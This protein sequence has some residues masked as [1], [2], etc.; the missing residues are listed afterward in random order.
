MIYEIA[1]D[2]S[3]SIA[4]FVGM[5]LRTPRQRRTHGPDGIYSQLA[6]NYYRKDKR[7]S[8]TRIIYNF[9]RADQVDAEALRRL[10]QSL[11]RVANDDRIDLP[12]RKFPPDVGIDDIEQVYTYGVLYAARALWEELGIGPLLR[13]KM[14]QDGCAA[15]HD[16]ALLALTANR[17]AR[18]TSKLACY[19]QWLAD[20]VYWPEAK[21][22]ALE[23]LYRAMDFLLRHIASLEQE[24]FYRTADRFN[25]DVDLVFWDTTTL[26]FEID[27]EDETGEYWR[28]QEIPALRKR[29][30][31]KDGRDNNPQVVVGLALTRDGLPVRSWVFPGN[32]ADVTTIEHLKADL[33]GW[34]LNRC[35]FVGDSGMFSEANQQ[36]LSRALGRDILAVPMRKVTEVPLEVLSR[37]GRYREVA[38]NL[39][40]KEV[41][42]GDGERRRRYLVC[43]NSEEAERE[44]AHRDRLLELVRAEIAVLDTRAEDHPKPACELIASRR[45]GRYLTMDARGRLS[46]NATKVA[47]EATYDGKFVLTTN[48]DTLD[49][50]D[51]ALGY[52]SMMLIEG[53]FR[54]MK[55]TGLQTRPVYH[56]KPHRIIAH[57]KLCVLALRLERAAEIRCQNTWRHIRQALDQLQVVRYRMHGKTIG[58]STQVTPTVGKILDRLRVPLPKKILEVSDETKVGFLT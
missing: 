10:A 35:V 49:A 13:A 45:F 8:E 47:A 32:T 6:E 57:V 42:V 30:H 18:P 53:C 20:A 22:L 2:N 37:P 17:L 44:Q 36:R 21:T 39:R 23:H 54:R 27:A 28:A 1:L 46:I 48:D 33:R 56:W 19:E 4:Y 9:G 26:Y 7:R 11:L 38:A 50:E 41:L 12:A 24:L 15:P 31:S 58:Q 3:A 5:Y 43:H 51:V 29:G 16:A 52:K 25:A 55:T 40:V 34:R 14:Q